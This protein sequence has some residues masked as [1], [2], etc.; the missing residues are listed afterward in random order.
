[1]KALKE[2]IVPNGQLQDQLEALKVRP[3]S[4]RL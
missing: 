3:V 1:M 4:K 2:M